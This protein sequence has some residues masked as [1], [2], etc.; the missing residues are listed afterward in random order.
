MTQHVRVAIIGSGFS[1]LGTAIKLRESGRDDF[2]VL[3]RGP[4]IGGTWRVNTYPGCACDVPSQVYS[5]SYELN[6]EW[7]HVYARQ[8]E[9]QAYLLRVTEKYDLRRQIR[10]DTAVTDAQW[11]ADRQLWEIET[12]TGPLTADVLVAGVGGLS[13]PSSP[14]IAGLSSFEG[15]VFHSAEW[16][17]SWSSEGRRVAVIGTGSSAIQFVPKIQPDAAQL[18]LFQRTASWVL[19]RRDRDITGLEKRVYRRFPKAQRVMRSLVYTRSEIPVVSFRSNGRLLKMG[20][21]MSLKMLEKQVPDPVLREKLT[22]HFDLGCKRILLSNHYYPALSADNADVITDRIVQVVP[23]G[24]VTEAADGS[25]TTHEVDTLILGTGF[26][27]QDPPIAHHVSVDGVTLAEHWKKDLGMQALHGISVSGFP[28]FFF[29]MGPNTALGHN[30][31]VLMIEAQ[32]RHLIKA[33]DTLD[34]TGSRTISPRLEVQQ[35]FDAQIQHDLQRSVWNAGGC[36]SWYRNEHGR[37][38]VLWPTFT[39]TYM[40]MMDRFDPSE[41]DIA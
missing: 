12:S 25:R 37:N 22:P 28:N 35:H 20:E 8:P 41:Y 9:I 33:L 32:I 5:F 18:L 34:A 13:E 14:D 23:T 19:P 29:L 7:S 39:F 17:S 3:E 4:D 16:A 38:T 15:T 6:P 1:G 31:V 26:R 30:S 27:V 40:R 36:S 10:F 11:D 24:I 2:V 21:K